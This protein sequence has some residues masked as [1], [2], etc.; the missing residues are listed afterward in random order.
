MVQQIEKELETAGFQKENRIYVPH[1]TVA[2]IRS[3]ETGVTRQKNNTMQSSKMLHS[4]ELDMKRDFGSSEVRELILY[5][6]QPTPD[7]SS[8]NALIRI[9]LKQVS[10]PAS[11]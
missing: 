2:K 11:P 9:P 7:G 8:Y 3:P 4:L 6:S 5:Q 1:L 10:T